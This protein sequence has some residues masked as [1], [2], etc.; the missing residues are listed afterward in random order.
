MRFIVSRI[1]NLLVS[2]N[3]I[4][5]D[6]DELDYYRYGIEI[7]ISSILNIV[8]ILI[9][10]AITRHFYESVVFLTVFITMRSFA[11]GFHANTYVRCNLIMCISFLAQTALYELLKEK[12][13]VQPAVIIAAVFSAVIIFFS[14]VENPNK[15]ITLIQKKRFR[16]ISIVLWILFAVIGVILIHN[17]IYVGVTVI[18]TMA[19]VSIMIVAAK[20]KERG[21]CYEKN[22]RKD[23]QNI[24]RTYG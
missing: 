6:S 3:V 8:L 9:L 22:N 24:H 12:I 21:I 1:L 5:N 15:T 7:S 14:P 19:L 2:S 18:L 4:K 17:Q 11:G 20:V 16:V 10:G 23:N 13:S